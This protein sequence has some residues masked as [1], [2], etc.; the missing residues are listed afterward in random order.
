M[1]ENGVHG[2]DGAEDDEDIDDSASYG[3]H[4]ASID[5]HHIIGHHHAHN[6]EDELGNNPF[7]THRPHQFSE[8]M[9]AEVGSP[10]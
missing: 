3:N 6:E 7:V 10:L 4:W 8:V 2:F 9:V 1:L 5:D